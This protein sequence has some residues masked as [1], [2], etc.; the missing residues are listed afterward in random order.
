MK[1]SLEGVDGNAFSIMS[2]VSNA[3]RKEGIDKQD[4]NTYQKDAMAGDYNHL[5]AHS[6]DTL[7]ILNAEAEEND[8]IDDTDY[9]GQVD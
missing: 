5:L 6:M 8:D 1:Y 9:W 3:M 2:F 7:D 4:I